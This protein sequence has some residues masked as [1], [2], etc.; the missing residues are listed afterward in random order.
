MKKFTIQ[1]DYTTEVDGKKMRVRSCY[2]SISEDLPSA[3][4]KTKEDLTHLA[5]LKLGAF[6]SGWVIM[7]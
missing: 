5:S 4:K 6:M 3:Y 1:I 7:G 2:Q